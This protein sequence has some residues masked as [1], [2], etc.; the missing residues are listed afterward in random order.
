MQQTKR[1]GWGRLDR[2]TGKG[3]RGWLGL[4]AVLLLVVVIG[5]VVSPRFLAVSNLMNVLNAASLVGIIVVGMT[6]VMIS[7]SM[8][9][10]SVPATVAVGAIVVLAAQAVVGDLPAIGIAALVAGLAGLVNGTLIGYGKA[11]PIIVTLG[12]GT[13]V[14]GFAQVITGGAIVYGESTP[15]S[16]FLRS[17]VGGVPVLVGVF[18]V[19]AAVGHLV[20]SRTVWGRW[21]YA[22]GSNYRA[23]EASAIPARRTIAAGFIL[24]GVLA[25]ISGS[26]LGLTLQQAR[27]IV[28]IGYEFAAIT[29]VVVGGVSLMGGVGNIPRAMAG[30]L[31]IVLVNNVLV[32]AGVPTPAQG[33][34]QGAIIAAAVAADV[35]ARR[36]GGQA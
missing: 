12:V 34:V 6:F 36:R 26:L 2:G 21:T 23:A 5:V 28:G 17:R 8:A 10:L 35:Y 19:F 16:D 7:G 29:A 9:D 27:P 1:R 13:I 33:L 32:L 25:G 18:V 14:L 30:V 11:N 20:L 24:S 15:V 3:A 22:V 4:A 31:L